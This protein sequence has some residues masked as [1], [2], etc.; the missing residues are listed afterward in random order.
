[1]GGTRALTRVHKAKTFNSER[2]RT[3]ERQTVHIQ[4]ELKLVNLSTEQEARPKL[5]LNLK[6]LPT[7]KEQL[8]K[9]LHLDT[10]SPGKASNDDDVLIKLQKLRDYYNPLLHENKQHEEAY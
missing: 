6:E 5:A 4:E 2:S 7:T 3:N 8:V 9:A 10:P 1:M